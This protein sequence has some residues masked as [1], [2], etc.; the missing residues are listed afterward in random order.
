MSRILAEGTEKV[1][2]GFSVFRGK[3]FTVGRKCDANASRSNRLGYLSFDPGNGRAC[4]EEQSPNDK[5]EEQR[6]QEQKSK[7]HGH[8]LQETPGRMIDDSEACL[9]EVLSERHAFI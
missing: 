4:R 3:G 8:Q 9:L 7:D 5:E 1:H 6:G 2:Q